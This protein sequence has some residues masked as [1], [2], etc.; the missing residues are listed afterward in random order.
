LIKY[1]YE[2]QK[3]EGNYLLREL[4]TIISQS[5]EHVTL[6]LSDKSHPL[7]KAHF[8]QY[9]ILPG[10]ALIDIVAEVLHEEVVYIKYS[11]FIANIFPDDILECT[12]DKN[13]KKRTIKVYRNNKKVSEI[14]YEAK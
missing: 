4:Y 7:F 14:V 13:E 5:F 1:T 2:Y 11:K 8:P 6:K 3:G 12:I 9:S 10:F